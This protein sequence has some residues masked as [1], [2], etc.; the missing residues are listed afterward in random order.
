MAVFLNQNLYP[1]EFLLHKKYAATEMFLELI[2]THSNI[3]VEIALHLMDKYSFDKTELP[4]EYVIQACLLH[5]I[6]VYLCGGF[7]WIP[8]QPPSNYPYIQHGVIGAWILEREGYSPKIIQ[9]AHSHIGVGFTVEDIRSHAINLPEQDFLP[10]T[11]LQ[12]FI[13]YVAKFH[14]KAPKFRTNDQI[15]ASLAAFNQEK[16]Q[17]FEELEKTYGT[18]DMDL[19][20]EKFGEWNRS[21]SF[22]AQ[23]FNKAGAK[24]LSPAG[25]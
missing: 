17:I 7:E 10:M 13:T 11:P 14:S 22:R 21:F 19:F 4:R 6:G 2:W 3:I 1:G 16:V 15:K 25:V 23:Q 18:P 8:N 9:V 12:K 20:E 24:P 5:D